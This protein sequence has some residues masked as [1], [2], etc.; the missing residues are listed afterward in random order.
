MSSVVSVAASATVGAA[1]AASSVVA[2]TIS[3]ATVVVVVASASAVVA[4]VRSARHFSHCPGTLAIL[5]G[6]DNLNLA[7]IDIR[8]VKPA[9]SRLGIVRVG[10]L[11]KS[12]PPRASRMVV[13]R[14]VHVKNFPEF[15]ECLLEIL[16]RRSE[17][18]AP[19]EHTC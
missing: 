6:E 11:D 3:S 9:D 14:E 16:T 17:I 4:I 1:P 18:D 15:G 10:E 19:D 7:S 2:R 12:K 8:P 5:L 13:Q